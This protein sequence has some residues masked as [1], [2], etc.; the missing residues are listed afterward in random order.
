MP[1]LTPNRSYPYPLPTDPTNVAGSPDA[2]GDIELLAEAMD[3][4]ITENLEP[5]AV[6]PRI[7]G[8]MRA[9]Q[10]QTIVP[11]TETQ[12]SFQVEYQDTDDMVNVINNPTL[13]TIN[14]S[15]IYVVWALMSVPFFSEPVAGPNVI[16]R[17]RRN[18]VEQHSAT[19]NFQSSAQT[20]YNW[21][22]ASVVSCTA[23][24][25][26][27]VTFSHNSTASIVLSTTREF[28]AAR[29]AA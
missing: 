13:M 16:M 5:V 19:Q 20:F 3:D 15:G 1:A 9:G 21:S 7:L 18:G 8:H 28:Y 17:L 2:P 27:T 14:T 11:N 24:D 12:L 6:A 4:D 22:I 26:L 25:N 10:S 23:G 29:M